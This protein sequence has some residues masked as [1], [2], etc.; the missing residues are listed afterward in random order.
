M[1]TPFILGRYLAFHYL[2]WFAVFFFLL[3]GLIY[4][5]DVTELMRRAAS[6]QGT[7]ADIVLKMAL[8]KVPETF[9]RILPFVVLFAAMF[10]FW[11][12]TR[13]H[14]L[15]VVRAAG[16]SVWQFLCP[17]IVVTLLFTCLHLALINPIGAKLNATFKELESEYLFRAPSLELTGAGLWLR[18]SDNE[19][20][21]LIHADKA[22]MSPLRLMPIMI[23]VFDKQ[24]QYKGRL[25]APVGTLINGYWEMK[26]VWTNWDQQPPVQI[27]DY[28]IRTSLTE[29]RIQES[30][31]APNTISFWELPSFIASLNT[32]G[33]PSTRH[34][35]QYQSLLALPIFLSGMI[36]FA[37]IF[38]LRMSRHGQASLMT[39]AALVTGGLA[40]ALNNVITALG[41]N[42]T[43]PVLLAAYSAP[44]IN[45]AL[46]V[47]V[48]LYR[49]DG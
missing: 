18:Q 31:A 13:N 7:T 45:F 44:L 24:D 36:F 38:C 22:E 40:F 23:L 25:D 11:R 21:Y 34:A 29:E 26:D 10:S 30:M 28:R 16:V 46:G 49:E 17:A 5:F 32:I 9:E 47:V 3:S 8:F 42:Q 43:L 4:L 35:M 2:L 1:K 20:N 39:V 48:L 33:L 6:K 27:S 14:E 37:A 12:L 15:I 41:V 19:H